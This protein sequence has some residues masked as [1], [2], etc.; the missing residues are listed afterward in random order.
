LDLFLSS[1]EG[2]ETLRWVLSE[3]FLSNSEEA[4]LIKG[5]NFSVTY[6]HSN[7]DMACATESV[8]SKLSQTLGMEFR[9]KIRSM[10]KRPNSSMP[11]TN[12]KE[13]KALKSSRFNKL[14]K[15]FRQ[16]K[17]TL[18]Y[19]PGFMDERKVRNFFQTKNCSFD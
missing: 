8:V 3:Q 13:L 6:P 16:T 5:L 7:L 1:A 17:T 12:E 4:V 15:I 18:C 11:N 9:W 14:L 10:L 19:S 2:K